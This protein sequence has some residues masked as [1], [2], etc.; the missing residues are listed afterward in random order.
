VV[1]V[2]CLPA[3]LRVSVFHEFSTIKCTGRGTLVFF[4][5]SIHAK[6][7]KKK[8]KVPVSH[9]KELK[10]KKTKSPRPIHFL[11]PSLVRARKRDSG[12]EADV[13]YCV[14]CVYYVC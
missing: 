6:E 5:F 11:C 13:L 3:V 4:V 12:Q 9:T 7:W 10:K 8:P 14:C 1:R 2:V